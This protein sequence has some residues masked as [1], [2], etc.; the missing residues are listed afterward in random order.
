LGQS[1]PIFHF[2]KE[3]GK[4][5]DFQEA[6]KPLLKSS[7]QITLMLLMIADFLVN[8]E[9]ILGSILQNSY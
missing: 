9:A 3:N 2:E 6:T 5:F 7:L 8:A 1:K 4:A